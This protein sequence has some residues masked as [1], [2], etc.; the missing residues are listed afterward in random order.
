MTRAEVYTML[1]TVNVPVA[2]HHFA[3]NTGQQPPFICF[4]Y[5]YDDDF[6]ADNANYRRIDTLFVELYTNNKDF[7]L[8]ESLE[9]VLTGAGLVW[10]KTEEY[11]SAEKMYMITYTTEVLIDG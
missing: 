5:P 9:A 8:E 7:S 10:R 1:C 11:I 3:E 6:K 4:Y 2:Y